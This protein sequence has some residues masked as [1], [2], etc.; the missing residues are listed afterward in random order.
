MSEVHHEAQ[1]EEDEAT[2]ALLPSES[3]WQAGW[4]T[5]PGLRGAH[6]EMLDALDT[7]ERQLAAGNE[8]PLIVLLRSICMR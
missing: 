6:T 1:E 3:Y 8:D 7:L 5:V 4:Q 2:Q